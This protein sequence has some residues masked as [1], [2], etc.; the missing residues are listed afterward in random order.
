MISLKLNVPNT[1]VTGTPLDASNA[2]S[3]ST[4]MSPSIQQLLN[5]WLKPFRID[6]NRDQKDGMVEL[7]SVRGAPSA[8]LPS[9]LGCG[10]VPGYLH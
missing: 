8:A 4:D 1:I 6:S 10:A 9:E 2:D 7:V 3:G 5:P